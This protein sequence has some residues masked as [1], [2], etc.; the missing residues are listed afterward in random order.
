MSKLSSY[1]IY[2]HGDFIGIVDKCMTRDEAAVKFHNHNPE[3][4]ADGLMAI[5]Y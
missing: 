5:P 4:V 2:F 3:Y 1:R